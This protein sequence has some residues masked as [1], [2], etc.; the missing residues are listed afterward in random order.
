MENAEALREMMRGSGKFRFYDKGNMPVVAFGLK[1][2]HAAYRYFVCM[3]L[4][5]AQF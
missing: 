5:R 3:L 2:T 1:D 4:F